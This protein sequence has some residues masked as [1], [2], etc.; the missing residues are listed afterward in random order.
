MKSHCLQSKPEFQQLRGE[1]FYSFRLYIAGTNFKSIL[2]LKTIKY[3]CETYLKDHY[4]L[5]VIDVYQQPELTQGEPIV[6]VPTLIRLLPLPLQRI[7]GDL[8]QTER[9]LMAL[10][11]SF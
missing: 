7:I 4:D 11:L 8:S 9:I 1:N 10:N 3:I 6:A 2:A 5:E